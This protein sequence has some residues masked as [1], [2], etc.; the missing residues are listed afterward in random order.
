MPYSSDKKFSKPSFPRKKNHSSS[1]FPGK[2]G[3]K[4]FEKEE[5]SEDR[6]YKKPSD[7]TQKSFGR[8]SA[9]RSE[10]PARFKKPFKRDDEKGFKRTDKDDRSKKSFGRD[11]EKK[12]FKHPGKSD[13]F[14]KPFKRDGET[15]YKKP[16]NKEEGDHKG[17]RRSFKPKEENSVHK[18][19]FDRDDRKNFKRSYGKDRDEREKDPAH[20]DRDHK[21]PYPKK[22]G[23]SPS[24]KNET[25][26][27]P[28]FKRPRK[29]FNDKE[30]GHYR[31][32]KK[33]YAGDKKHYKDDRVSYKKSKSKHDAP[34]KEFD[35][36]TRLN[37]YLSNA[38]ICSRRE[39]DDLIRAGA[40]KVNGVVVTEMGFKVKSTD[41]I[42][43]GGETLKNER[44]VY[45]LLNKP[46]DY[47][48][49]TDDPQE[50]HTVMELIDGACKERVYPVGRLDRNTVGLL[51]F[52]NDG[53]MAA[54][55][56]HPKFQV[57]KVYQVTLDKNLKPDDFKQIEAGIELED[58]L[59]K[60]DELSYV[61]DSKREIG[62]EIH[63]GKNR[64]VRRI[65]EHLGYE[66]VKL[67]RVAYAGL[68]K[69]DLPRG[70]WRFLSSKEVGFLNM[71]S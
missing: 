57:R 12:G 4:R 24:Y 34:E 37:K 55:L 65:F 27:K 47:I 3:P 2:P 10:K 49:T 28:S 38:G 14:K 33:E 52:T 56:M 22:E 7:R 23:G 53:E 51:L 54:K 35:G 32:F 29:Q 30:E 64:I 68:T 36:L 70:K 42:N 21:K 48:T 63:S 71:I 66:I 45:L 6:P 20:S 39:A 18:K 60:P 13:R 67:D 50:R 43:Y 26:E 5:S 1:K 46:K 31:P 41:V 15:G 61:N 44:K 9:K 19:P 25:N 62:I 8:D 58:G 59:I 69:K 16:F 40:V 11:G 17:E